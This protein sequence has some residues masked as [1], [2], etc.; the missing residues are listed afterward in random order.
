MRKLREGIEYP[1]LVKF[2]LIDQWA[3]DEEELQDL[4]DKAERSIANALWCVIAI[5]V[6]TPVALFINQFVL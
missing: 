6:A 3:H 5:A 2:P 1:V 4:L